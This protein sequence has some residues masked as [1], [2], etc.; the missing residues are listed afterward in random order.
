M[1]SSSAS[2]PGP[3]RMALCALLSAL[4]VVSLPRSALALGPFEKNH[5]RVEQGMQAYQ[6]GR[7]EDALNAFEAARKELPQNAT[8]EFDRGNALYKLRRLDE[9]KEAYHRVAELDRGELQERDYY[10]LGNALAELGQAKD[11]VAAYRKALLLDPRDDQAR[12]N[13][14]VV[15][16]NI[17][18]PRRPPPQM[19]GGDEDAGR[20]AGR[21]GGAD[22]GNQGKGDSGTP[23]GGRSDAGPPGGTGDGGTKGDGGTEGGQHDQKADGGSSGNDK[24][25][26]SQSPSDAGSRPADDDFKEEGGQNPENEARPM[27]ELNKKDVERLLDSMKQSEKNLQLWRFQQRKKKSGARKDNEKDW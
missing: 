20:D 6:D 19:D 18:P 14:E 7:Y 17:P 24:P 11:A 13:M 15:L 5:P 26:P 23:D 21:D 22:G 9:A 16:R 25:T 2:S 8:V 27:P 3:G 12:H 4:L 10:N 1:S